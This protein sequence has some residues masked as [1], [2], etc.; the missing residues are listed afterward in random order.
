MLKGQYGVRHH[1]GP[2]KKYITH[3]GGGGVLHS[4]TRKFANFFNGIQNSCIYLGA[5]RKT[6]ILSDTD[7]SHFEGQ[8]TAKLQ[9]YGH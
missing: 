6:G 3:L 8:N 1:K 5:L 4:G 2:L 7:I 9:F